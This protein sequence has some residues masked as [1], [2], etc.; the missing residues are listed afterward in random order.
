MGKNV[1]FLNI[2]TYAREQETH[3]E[4]SFEIWLNICK[5]NQHIRKTS[6]KP[7][8]LRKYVL[9]VIGYKTKN[10]IIDLTSRIPYYEIVSQNIIFQFH[11]MLNHI[12]K[13]LLSGTRGCVLCPAKFELFSVM[14]E[15]IIISLTIFIDNIVITRGA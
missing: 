10:L 2:F 15:V 7:T 6:K 11:M 14:I 3:I 1:R 5:Y 9:R 8:M 12:N 13:N 4:T